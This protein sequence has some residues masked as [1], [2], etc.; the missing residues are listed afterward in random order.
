MP[1]G[2]LLSTL[3]VVARKLERREHEIQS[4]HRFLVKVIVA[5]PEPAMPQNRSCFRNGQFGKHIGMRVF[6]GLPNNS[7]V[8]HCQDGQLV[9]A[10]LAGLLC[11]VLVVLKAVRGARPQEVQNILKC[12]E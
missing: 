9:V 11:P 1:I 8:F 10:S 5:A 3:I 2:G 4:A 7:F 12:A 6:D